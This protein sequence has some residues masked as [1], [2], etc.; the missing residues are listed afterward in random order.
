MSKAKSLT[1]PTPDKYS[2]YWFGAPGSLKEPAILQVGEIKNHV[3]EYMLSLG[4]FG[5]VTAGASLKF[6]RT[7][8]EALRD[9]NVLLP[10]HW[11]RQTAEEKRQRE[12]E[13]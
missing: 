12:K 8:Q 10:L 7:P 2:N 4:E 13:A 6:Y 11:S 5:V 1:L 3:G 9:L